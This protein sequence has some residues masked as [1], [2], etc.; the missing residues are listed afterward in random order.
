MTLSRSVGLGCSAGRAALAAAAR[1]MIPHIERVRQLSK[2]SEK[3]QRKAEKE[4][5]KFV[6]QLK[7]SGH[8]LQRMLD[9]ASI[10]AEND[11]W[12]PE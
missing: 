5:E 7:I 12:Q 1:G 9:E 2:E 4:E 3:W 8:D 11:R 10:A 6:K